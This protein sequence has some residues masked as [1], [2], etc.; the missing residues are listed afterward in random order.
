M[1]AAENISAEKFGRATLNASRQRVGE[2]VAL[3]QV[4]REEERGRI[5]REIH[6][7]LA[8][9]L[10]WL[11]MDIV[12]LKRRLGQ[13]L[14][15]TGRRRLQDELGT[16]T[17]VVDRTIESVQKI[18][19]ELRPAV[20]DNLG[21]CAAIEWQVKQFEARSGIHCKANLPKEEP[22]LDRER[23]AAL[24]RIVQES[25]TNA[26]RHAGASKVAVRLQREPGQIVLTVRDNGR[27]IEADK[28]S[29]PYSAG[30][31]G[32]RERAFLYGG[33][34]EIS[35]RFRGG[36]AVEVRL[37]LPEDQVLEENP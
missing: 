8:Q 12:W 7:M 6:D 3:L 25:L 22:A 21:L 19:G 1:L 14:D 36:T 27:G 35:G 5:A 17:E 23:S 15:E 30:L 20:L 29:G 9:D 31:T 11:K 33:S 2:L 37:P 28:L 16:M 18:A 24:F 4:V 32:M 26:V 10:T 13:P 34:C